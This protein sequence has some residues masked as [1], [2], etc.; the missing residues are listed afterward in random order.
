MTSFKRSIL[1]TIILVLLIF[2]LGSLGALAFSAK[3]A[4]DAK[5]EI[6]A[7]VSAIEVQQLDR[8]LESLFLIEADLDQAKKWK[9]A[10]FWLKYVPVLR[11]DYIIYNELLDAGHGATA[12]IEAVV[13]NL[14]SDSISRVFSFE[15]LDLRN[16]GKAYL[17]VHDEILE[18]YDHLIAAADVADKIHVEL[19][20]QPY[21]ADIIRLQ[22][23]LQ[24][25]R[26]KIIALRPFLEALPEALGRGDP[27]EIL[28][29]LE[30]S[31]ELRPTGGF[32][33]NVARLTLDQGEIIQF[34]TDDVYSVD[35]KVLGREELRPPEPISK[36]MNVEYW[37]LRDSN[38]SP[39]YPTAAQN[40]KALYEFEMQEEGIDTVLALTPFIIEGF[41]DIVGPIET[42]GIVFTSANL[43]EALQYRVEYGFAELGQLHGERKQIIK[44]LA[45]LI[46]QRFFTMNKDE[47]KQFYELGKE[48]LDRKE[49]L[50]YTTNPQHQALIAG[51]GWDG[52]VIDVKGDYIYVSDANVA[53]LKTDRVVERSRKYSLKYDGEKWKA[54]LELTYANNGQFDYRTTRY[55]TY[56]RVYVPLGSELIASNGFVET[57]KSSVSIPPLIY[58]E[59]GKTVFAGFLSVEPGQQRTITLEYYL[60][61]WLAKKIELENKYS[62]YLQKQPGVNF[63]IFE[64]EISSNKKLFSFAPSNVEYQVEGENIIKFVDYTTTDME[65]IVA[66]Q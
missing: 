44:D 37:Y 21:R 48:A 43:I 41:L 22:Q 35:G 25:N 61:D 10:S 39:D 47:M 1:L 54:V 4:L 20:P 6:S 42:G 65:Y 59:F 66:Y 53:A 32:I 38:W 28:V 9:S 34:S 51:L 58:S 17:E 29:L 52:R 7:A 2:V 33:G 19:I 15:S 16:A 18:A 31:D 45:D 64:A 62:L 55:R 60:P 5:K 40:V 24:E 13:R 63:S 50:I 3:S 49:I 23:S 56:T 12:S 57:D 8:A 36:Y 30:N 27:H 26:D 11:H 14:S 46:K